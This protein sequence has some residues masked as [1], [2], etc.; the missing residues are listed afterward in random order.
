MS[1]GRRCRFMFLNWFCE[2]GWGIIDIL[3]GLG[4]LKVEGIGI[5]IFGSRLKGLKFCVGLD[6]DKGVELKWLYV[7][8]R[9][10]G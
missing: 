1:L 5:L 2:K 6:G 3:C 9:K 4:D 7:V 10:L 8:F